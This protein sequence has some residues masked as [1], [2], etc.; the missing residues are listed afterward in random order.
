MS[1]NPINRTVVR[2]ADP[3]ET[4]EWIEALETIVE[5]EGLERAQYVLA[6][7][8]DEARRLG[9]TTSGLPFSAYRNTI[10]VDRQPAYPGDLQ[11]EQRITS[12]IRWNA[13]AMVVRANKAFGELGGHIAT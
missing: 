2:D 12:I 3:E 11:L 13:L 6:T 5:R 1:K 8:T 7:V 10:P 9:V 4:T